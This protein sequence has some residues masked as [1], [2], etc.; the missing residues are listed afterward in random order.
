MGILAKRF[1]EYD[2]IL[3]IFRDAI[4]REVWMAYYDGFSAT[5]AD[6]F[7]TYLDP[8]ADMSVLDIASGP[9]LKRVV[10]AKLREV[11]GDNA[12]VV[13]ILVPGSKE[14]EL[15]AQFWCAF[16][17]AGDKHPAVSVCAPDLKAACALLGLPQEAWKSLAA[18]VET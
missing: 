16:E 12:S 10:A 5:S 11:Y 1:P 8:S 14:Q 2:L 7:I 6:R 9:E 13:S 17:G 18:A 3:Q 15:Y 4:T